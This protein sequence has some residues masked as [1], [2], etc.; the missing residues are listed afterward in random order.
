[1]CSGESDHFVCQYLPLSHK[2]PPAPE[3]DFFVSLE[4]LPSV[5]VSVP[6]VC[7]CVSLWVSLLPLLSQHWVWHIVSALSKLTIYSFNKRVLRAHYEVSNTV[8]GTGGARMNSTSSEMMPRAGGG[9]WQLNNRTCCRRHRSDDKWRWREKRPEP[10]AVGKPEAGADLAG[11]RGERCP[12][13]DTETPWASPSLHHLP[14]GSWPPPPNGS[15]LPA[16]HLPHSQSIFPPNSQRTH[17]KILM[18]S[19]QVSIQSSKVCPQLLE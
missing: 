15:P 13:A 7:L 1:M 9:G 4:S 11:G 8:M 6:L 14:R 5:Y 10:Q 18:R 12:T 3:N 17:L 2:A 16:P 19:S